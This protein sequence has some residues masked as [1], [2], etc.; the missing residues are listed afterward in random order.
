M[1]IIAGITVALQ[2]QKC[3]SAANRDEGIPQCP[4]SHQVAR[5]SERRLLAK[6]ADREDRCAASVCNRISWFD[7]SVFNLWP[8]RLSADQNYRVVVL[9]LMLIADLRVAAN[10]SLSA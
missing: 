8:L 3:A 6:S 10:A 2:F 9:L 7:P 1:R 4:T 5:F